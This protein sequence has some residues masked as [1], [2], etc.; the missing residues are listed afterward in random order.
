MRT[1]HEMLLRDDNDPV[2]DSL[3]TKCELSCDLGS[4]SRR[5]EKYSI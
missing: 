3:P 1:L 5:F 2:D 4:I